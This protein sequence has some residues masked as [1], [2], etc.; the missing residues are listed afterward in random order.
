VSS[1]AKAPSAGSNTGQVSRFGL[2]FLLALVATM[3]LGASSA[4]AISFG[5]PGSGDG[6]LSLAE[7][8]GLAVNEATHDIYV[9]DTANHRVSQF[10]ASG[11][12]VR[13][14][15]ADVGGPGVNVCTSGC[16]EGTSSSAPGAFEAPTFVAIDNSTGLSKGSVYVADTSSRIVTKFEANGTLVSSWGVGGQLNGSTATGAFSGP[17]ETIAGIAVDASGTLDVFE[18]ERHA[19]FQFEPDGTFVTD[20]ET[21]RGTTPAGLAVDPDGNFFKFNGFPNVE[22]FG[23]SGADIGQVSISETSAG[24]LL[25]KTSS[26]LTADLSNGELYVGTGQAIDLYTFG[27][28]GEVIGTGCTPVPFE[29][30]VFVGCPPTETFGKG[31]FSATAG[32]SVD[33]TSHTVYAADFATSRIAAFIATLLAKISTGGASNVLQTTATLNGSVTPGNVELEDC[34]FE[35]GETAA[36]GQSA[37]CAETPAEVGTGSVPQ[38]VHADLTGLAPAGTQYH[39]RLVVSNEGGTTHGEDKTFRTFD[40]LGQSVQSVAA[41]EAVLSTQI[42]PGGSPTTFRIEYGADTSYGQSSAE[43]NA[44]SDFSIHSLSVGLSGLTPNTVYHWR[45]VATNALGTAEGSDQTFST[46]G[47]APSEGGCTNQ[48]FRIGASARLPDCRAY[49]MVSPVDK[50]NTDIL[51]LINIASTIGTLNQSSI[52]GEKLTYTTSQ[53]FGDAQ[54]T[55]YLS[56]YLAS[57]GPDGWHNHGISPPQ[58]VSP[59]S[60]GSRIDIEFRA[61]TSDLCSAALRY[62]TD[63]PL[64]PGAPEGFINVYVRSNCGEEGYRA[65]ITTAP[66]FQILPEVQGFSSDGQCV[67]FYARQALTPDANPGFNRQLYESCGGP[68]RLISTLPNGEAFAGGSSVGTGTQ[69]NPGIRTATS[70]R[71]VSADGSRVYWTA[72][73]EYPNA[74]YLRD[75]A[76]QPQSAVAAGEC[77]EPAKACTVT[78]SP[79][80]AQFWSA[81]PDGSKALYTLVNKG[82]EREIELGEL[83]EFDLASGTSSLIAPQATGVIG[84][85]ED[86]A[87]IA[88]V[89]DEVLSSGANAEGKAPSPGAPN[90]Y[91]FD[92]TQSDTDQFRFIGTLSSDDAKSMTGT[93]GKPSPVNLFPFK[94]SS[95]VSPDGRQIAFMSTARLTGYDNTDTVNGEADAEVYAYDATANGGEGELRCVSCNPSGRRP[96]GR[97]LTVEGY[98]SGLYAAASMPTYQTELYGSRVISDDGKRVFFDSYESLL[99]GDTNGKADVYQWEAPGSGSCTEASAAFSPLNEG[100]VSLISTGESPADSEFVDA[101]PDGR[102]IFFATD[103]SLRPEDPGLIDIYDARSGGGYPPPPTRT[104]ACEGEACQ[105]PLVPPNDA[106][107]SSAVFNGPGNVREAAKSRCAKSKKASRKGRCKKKAKPAKS[108]KQRAKRTNDNRRGER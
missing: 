104:A 51:S 18:Q 63:P 52:D 4:M 41:S 83:Y 23:P 89:S 20:F 3:A 10:S 66:P 11:A 87:R 65:A 42:S 99:P 102:D 55:P 27:P 71:A 90:L 80:P 78:V 44:G 31:S 37:P 86:A 64:V 97:N 30:P 8:S 59:L 29:F 13:A 91:F 81:S 101:S 25:D 7:H 92:S 50:N 54:G 56:Q 2:A 105:G 26:G 85:S 36:Y 49:E 21:P 53:G 106:T 77:T 73:W 84:A 62:D 28:S 14:F 39:Y 95:R 9:A 72:D 47:T 46:Y 107:P 76:D 38:P 22:K 35:Y 74:L 6:Q 94:K 45:V 103:S 100:C 24:I 75:N 60:I 32:L 1:H 88:F 33:G 15:G 17:F 68:L 40:I 16:Q 58:G 43:R 5:S 70:A 19:L 48:A 57:R 61:F 98:L 12:F 93:G 34:F 79:G 67:A 108:N 82:N 69:A 96:T